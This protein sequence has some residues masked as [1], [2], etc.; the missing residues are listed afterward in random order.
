MEAARTRCLGPP[1]R[2]RPFTCHAGE[3]ELQQEAAEIKN[4]FQIAVNYQSQNLHFGFKKSVEAMHFPWGGAKCQGKTKLPGSQPW[5]EARG[6]PGDKRWLWR[7]PQAWQ[8]AQAPACPCL[9]EQ[10]RLCS[11]ITDLFQTEGCRIYSSCCSTILTSFKS[12]ELLRGHVKSWTP[13]EILC[14]CKA[15]AGNGST[16][17]NCSAGKVPALRYALIP[18]LAWRRN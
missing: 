8:G 3:E 7:H 9:W 5:R 18:K 2:P 10:E 16:E 15:M 11:F 6:G 14:Y 4:M 13:Q 12:A 1:S 17:D